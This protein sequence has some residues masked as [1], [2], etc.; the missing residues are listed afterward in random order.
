MEGPVHDLVGVF[1]PAVGD[2]DEGRSRG[3]AVQPDDV[4][5]RVCSIPRAFEV[6]DR[7]DSRAGPKVVSAIGEG[8]GAR[9]TCHRVGIAAPYEEI[10]ASG[11]VED[12]RGA[13][14]EDGV[15]AA[16]AVD[17]LGSALAGQIHQIVPA[18]ARVVLG[19]RV[20]GRDC[21][22]NRGDDRGGGPIGYGVGE[23]VGPEVARQRGVG[24]DAVGQLHRTVGV[25]AH[26]DTDYR[27]GIAV[28]IGI[29][30]KQLRC[31]N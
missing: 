29:V 16:L 31:R 4:V 19:R 24:D 2:V 20:G 13:A 14:A 22:C 25:G 5:R 10:V 21:H 11:P 6:R 18:A 1:G 15:V 17:Q 28:H 3:E 9:A 27:Q 12:I 30:G 8:I 7:L 26:G 23:G